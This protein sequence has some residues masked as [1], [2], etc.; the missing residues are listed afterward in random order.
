MANVRFEFN[1]SALDELMK[2]AAQADVRR[3]AQAILAAAGEHY[4]IQTEVGRRRFRAAVI[5][6][7][8]RGGAHEAKHHSLLHA[9]DAGRG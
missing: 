3:R 2:H 1:Q 6:N 7:G 4:H 5:T 9:I 8:A